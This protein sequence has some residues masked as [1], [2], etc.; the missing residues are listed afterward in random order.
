[1]N[2]NIVAGG[3]YLNY[4]RHAFWLPLVCDRRSPAAT[5]ADCKS[6]FAA[7]LPPIAN[8]PQMPQTKNGEEINYFLHRFENGVKK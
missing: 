4:K 5:T 6:D 3:T 1:M 7:D 8:Q 2:Q